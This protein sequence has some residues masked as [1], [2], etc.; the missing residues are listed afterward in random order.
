[1]SIRHIGDVAVIGSV[2]WRQTVSTLLVFLLAVVVLGR[3]STTAPFEADEADYVATSRYFKYLFLQWDVSRPEWESNHWTRTQPPL[4]RYIIGVWLHAHGYDFDSLNQPYVSTASSFEVNVLKGRVPSDDVLATA[5]QPMVIFGAGAVAL[6]YLLGLVLGG[7]AAGLVAVALAL[8]SSLLRYTLV[9][10]WAEAPLAFFLLLSA[11]LAA[12]GAREIVRGGRWLAWSVLLG[13]ALGLASTTKLTGL[14]SA[15]I[16][17]AVAGILATRGAGTGQRVGRVLA[18]WSIVAVM[19]MLAVTIAANPFLWRGP[20]T[21]FAGMIEQRRDEMAFQQKQ[22]PEY[23]VLNPGERP[24][25]TAVGS[26]RVGLWG[27][28]EIV[29][30]SVGLSLAALGVFRCSRNCAKR[31]SDTPSLVV[32]LA[33][34]AGHALAIIAGLGLSYARYFLPSCLLLLPFMGAGGALLL[35]TLM[36]WG[37]ERGLGPGGGRP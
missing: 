8:T 34:L 15:P 12:V 24:W 37:R 1:L 13:L 2:R 36:K 23:A 7:T 22:W 26:T 9:H 16:L 18:K 6:V 21:G 31:R 28:S 5:R 11:L 25:L 20:M 17:L 3:E 30:T 4:T 32:A 29:A 27:D 19:V 33:W 10:A 14:V 35:D